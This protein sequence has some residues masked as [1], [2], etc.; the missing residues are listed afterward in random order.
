[1]DVINTAM[2]IVII[3]AGPAG[4]T[5]AIYAARAGYHA[6]I[7]E[8]GVPGGQVISTDTIDN[9]P[10]MKGIG[11]Y[12]MIEKMLEHVK[13]YDIEIINEPVTGMDIGGQMKS[14]VTAKKIYK[15]KTVIIAAGAKRRKLDV[16][17]EADFIGRGVSYCAIC[18]GHFYRKKDVAVVGGGY[19]AVEDAAYLARICSKVYII[20]RRDDFRAKGIE[21][22]HLK[23]LNNVELVMNSAV[24]AINGEKRLSEITVNNIVTGFDTKVNVSGLFIAVGTIPASEF[25]PIEINRDSDNYIITDENMMTNI[26]GVFAAGDIRHSP[27]KQIITA[28]SDG[29]VAALK[30]AVYIEDKIKIG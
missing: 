30:A 1:M 26:G 11:G 3:G 25:I 27:L 22:D 2:D 7:I 24:T 29:A 10:G 18:D 5:A 21:V 20:H 16:Y 6:V 12:E 13:T 8:S 4:L 15:T 14:V 19:T 28:A 23:S 9:F 17:G